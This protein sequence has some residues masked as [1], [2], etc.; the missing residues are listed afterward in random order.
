MAAAELKAAQ[1][2]DLGALSDEHEEGSSRANMWDMLIPIFLLIIFCVIGLIYVGGF[3]DPETNAGDFIAAFGDTDAF[4]GLPWGAL[5]A[6]VLSIIYLCARRVIKWYV[7]AAFVGTVFVLS[8][9]SAGSFVT[10]LYSVMA[11]GVFLGA[12]FMA[13]DY[14]TSPVT[15]L[16]QAIFA[17][18]CG[19]ITVFIR[20][21]GSYPEGVS[22]AIL[23][24]NACV[25][26]LDK[27]GVP[28]RF[29]V[30]AKGGKQ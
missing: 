28:R 2:G 1:T 14:V 24:M 16:G 29:G 5:I 11:G 19:L 6:L 4:V 8:L 23:V 30:P 27:I 25:V 15:K 21:F 3:W 9:V 7:P 17:V 12:I 10:A 26:L 22:Y 20:Y 13:T 18:G